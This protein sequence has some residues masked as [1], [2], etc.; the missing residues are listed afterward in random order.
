MWLS[1]KKIVFMYFY[2]STSDHKYE[3]FVLKSLMSI[4]IKYGWLK[5]KTVSSENNQK[6]T[7]LITGYVLLEF[8][9]E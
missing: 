7:F 2:I 3:L 9:T 6:L 1:K 4:I 8:G 5:R